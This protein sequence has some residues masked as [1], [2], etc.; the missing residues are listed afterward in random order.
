MPSLQFP[1]TVMVLQE[2]FNRAGQEPGLQVWRIEK[3]DLVPVPAALYGQFFE[4]DCYIVLYTYATGYNVHAWKGES[5]S[6][7]FVYGTFQSWFLLILFC[8]G[9]DCTQDESTAAV[10]IMTQ[11]DQR[12]GSVPVQY[13]ESERRESKVFISYFKTGIVYKVKVASC[14]CSSGSTREATPTEIK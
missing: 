2:Q 8:T 14:C 3:M 4:G 12:L 10:I 1:L 9:N 5:A 13:M 11:L 7:L 6:S